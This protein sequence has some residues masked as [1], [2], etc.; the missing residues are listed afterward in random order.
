MAAKK[1]PRSSQEEDPRGLGWLL[2]VIIAALIG[3]WFVVGPGADP[4]ADPQ[5]PIKLVMAVPADQADL[6][7][8]KQVIARY[9]AEHPHVAVEIRAIPGN[10]YYQ[11]LL[12]MLAS[13]LPPDLRWRGEG[14][15]EFASRGAFMD[16]GDRLDQDVDTS[17]FLPQALQWYRIDGQQLGAPYLIDVQFIVYNKKLFDEAGLAY[18]RDDWDYDEFLADAKK[19][20]VDR[21]GDGR[22]EQY[23]Y[24]GQLDM[25]VFGAQ[26]ISE[27]G[28]HAT[29]QT[30]AMMD[31]LN[32]NRSLF[33]TFH[34]SPSPQQITGSGSDVYTIFRQGK[35]AM[36]IAYT[37]DL[38]YLREQ[39]ADVDWDITLNPKVNQRGQWA[40]S[41]A[42]LIS[43]KTRH[44]AEAWELNKLFLGADFQLRMCEDGGLPPNLSVARQ[45]V[46][47]NRHKPAN[48]QALI[49]AREFLYPKPRIAN[50][51]ELYS[52]FYNACDT[53]WMGTATPAGAMDRAQ[54]QITW[55]I[56]RHQ[57][58]GE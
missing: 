47:Q 42:I 40:S 21:G 22:I 53:V 36:M 41:A 39:C 31:F 20:T 55:L 58:R 8:Y 30:P 3:G 24:Y 5:R 54:R 50:S 32:T 44:P 34:V 38:P 6:V 25:S 43:S 27:D 46:A 1:Q 13:G 51:A 52:Q 7:I 23:G 56:N 10:N 57:E 19:L 26:P 9:E 33:N 11:K 29:C 18:P 14:F 12:V 4:P 48:L 17:D 2:G 49:V 15:A 45:L 37:W 35:A 16:V 28:T